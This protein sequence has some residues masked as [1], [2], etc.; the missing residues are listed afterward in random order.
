MYCDQWDN[1]NIADSTSGILHFITDTKRENKQKVAQ[2][3]S[4]TYLHI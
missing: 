2:D 1:S 3:V 4:E